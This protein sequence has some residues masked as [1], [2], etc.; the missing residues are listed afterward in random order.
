MELIELHIL[1][2]FP[3]TC[4]NRDRFG[5]PKSAMFGGF[6]R[7]RVSSQAWKR[8]TRELA[9]EMMPNIFGASRSKILGPAIEKATRE[10]GANDRVSVAVTEIVLTAM[11]KDTNHAGWVETLFFFSPESLKNVIRPLI[12]TGLAIEGVSTSDEKKV[13][14]FDMMGTDESKWELVEKF[15]LFAP[16]MLEDVLNDF[17]KGDSLSCVVVKRNSEDKKEKEDAEKKYMDLMANLTK[18]LEKVSKSEGFKA[19]TKKSDCK[20]T[21]SS[22]LERFGENVTDAADIALFGRMVADDPSQTVEGAA[23]FSHAMSTHAVRSELDFFSA[24]DDE[25]KRSGGADDAGAGHLG[26]VEYNSACYYRYIGINLDLLDSEQKK[27]N[28]KLFDSAQKKVILETFLKA[29]ILAIPQARKN[30]MAGPT[31]PSYILAMKRSGQPL[32]L[33]NAFERPVQAKKGSGYIEPSV[34]ALEKEW[35]TME[36]C[37]S[38]KTDVLCKMDPKNIGTNE[39]IVSASLD[40]LVEKLVAD[41]G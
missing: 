3:P 13:L 15:N 22:I 32:S 35:S 7:A 9:H 11:K 33:A 30:S 24:V 29:A 28:C 14:L 31:Y 36:D 20:P 38:V 8:P 10:L 4:L 6:E 18:Q 2:S 12:K 26:D 23:M 5:A 27:N 25:K 21:K 40:K 1:Q 41:I 39:K 16:K 37:F 17:D 34:T 19:S